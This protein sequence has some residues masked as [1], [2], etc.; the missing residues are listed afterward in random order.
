MGAAR[1]PEGFVT[2]R[3]A[4]R[5][6]EEASRL[7]RLAF[8]FLRDLPDPKPKPIK[9]QKTWA[10]L[11]MPRQLCANMPLDVGVCQIET[12]QIV[13]IVRITN[14]GAV[15]ETDDGQKF[16]WTDRNWQRAWTKVRRL[17]TRRKKRS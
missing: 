13:T 15:L 16:W 4:P 8:S 9:D 1:H 11:D 14:Q 5:P 6:G 7:D 2:A 3:R 12:D 10:T 17:P